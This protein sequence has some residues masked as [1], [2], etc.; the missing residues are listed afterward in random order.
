MSQ[1]RLA[2]AKRNHL[3]TFMIVAA[4]GVTALISSAGAAPATQPALPDIP[5]FHTVAD[6]IKAKVADDKPLGSAR[7]GYLGVEVSVADGKLHVDDVEATSPAGRAGVEAGDVLVNLD[8]QPIATA[9]ALRNELQAHRPGDEVKL[10]VHR[11]KWPLSLDVILAATSRPMQLGGRRAM[12]GVTTGEETDAG[13]PLTRIAPGMPAEAAGLKA[14]DVLVKIDGVALNGSAK[15]S[16]NL[17]QK[18]PGDTITVVY[19]R[20]GKEAE[21]K[22]RLGAAPEADPRVQQNPAPVVWKKNIYR[23]AVICV[24]FPD[25]KHN[26]KIDLEDWDQS[27]FSSGIYDKKDSATGQAVHGSLHDYYNEIS[28][29][30][31][32]VEGQVFDWVQVGKKRTE[33]VQGSGNSASTPFLVEATDQ[34][35][36]REGNDA[37]SNFDGIMFLYA[38]DRVAG[39]NRGGLYWPHKGMFPFKRK[40]WNYFIVPEG[41]SRMDS[42]STPCHEFGHMLGLPDLY[43]RPEAPGSIGLGMWDAMSMQAGGGRPQHFSAWSKEQLGWIKPT[44]I[45]PAVKQKLILSPIENSPSECYKILIRPDGSEYL[46]LENRKKI[47]FDESLQGEGLLIWRVA[48]NRPVLEGSHGV[49]GPNGPMVYLS[50]V[51]YP[52]IANNAFTPYTT[53]SSRSILGGGLPVYLTNIRKLPDGR[54]TFYVGYEFQ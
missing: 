13:A 31:L 51:P 39:T 50:S 27:L 44:V 42:V 4:I 48:N 28:C 22:L 1:F 46:L 38:G 37:L 3:W 21:V 36:K 16:D 9:D 52:S 54:I 19:R 10:K 49:E 34:L 43:A 5:G 25:V 17:A 32:D 12:M 40:R 29:G 6:A 20:D 26:D 47:G 30:K 18:Q 35:L 11:G 14:G 8:D 45:D 7:T 23:L 33:Y 53:P 15:V 2:R 41:G 24:E